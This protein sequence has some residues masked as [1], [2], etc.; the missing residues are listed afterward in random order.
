M[1]V[2]TQIQSIEALVNEGVNLVFQLHVPPGEAARTLVHSPHQQLCSEDVLTCVQRAI[3]DLIE[4]ALKAQRNTPRFEIRTENLANA[5]SIR[6]EDFAALTEA[7]AQ[8]ARKLDLLY[9]ARSGEMKSLKCFTVSDHQY[10]ATYATAQARTWSQWQKFHEAAA[11][12]L[13]QHGV[14]EI[15]SLPEVTQVVLERLIP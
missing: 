15:A 1:A 2:A 3:G 11:E 14:E 8:A 10:R 13:V 6:D 12:A 4:E 7:A 9:A 5:A